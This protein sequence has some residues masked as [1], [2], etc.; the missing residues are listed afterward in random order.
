MRLELWGRPSAGAAGQDKRGGDEGAQMRRRGYVARNGFM[1]RVDDNDDELRCSKGPSRRASSHGPRARGSP[2]NLASHGRPGGETRRKGMLLTFS[3]YLIA[4]Y[5]VDYIGLDEDVAGRCGLVLPY[6]S[7]TLVA[8]ELRRVCS[9][10]AADL[11]AHGRA[12][13]R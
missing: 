6:H 1:S 13:R 12:E 7:S 2:H 5:A 9:Q 4:S 8:T 10:M 11:V 3:I